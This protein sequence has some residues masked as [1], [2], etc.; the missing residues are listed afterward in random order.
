M[1]T[2]SDQNA[3]HS[4]LWTR[5]L[6]AAAQ[7]LT[8]VMRWWRSAIADALTSYPKPDDSPTGHA[9]GHD[10]DRILI[11]GAGPAV[12]W[13]VRTHDRGLPGA[14]ARALTA[15]T[16]RGSD[17]HVVA[18]ANMRVGQAPAALIGLR[19]SQYDAVVVM[20]GGNDALRL[21]PVKRWR[22]GLTVLL[23]E[24]GEASPGIL[25]AVAGIQPIR[26]IGVFD[27]LLGGVA[28]RRGVS[29]NHVTAQ[30]CLDTPY[31]VFVSTAAR[32]SP[33]TSGGRHM[34]PIDFTAWAEALADRIAPILT[35][36]HNLNG[37]RRR[38]TL[39]AGPPAPVAG[40][41]QAG[42]AAGLEG[43]ASDRLDC[44]VS[45]A[46]RAFRTDFA[47][48]SLLDGN[49]R[50]QLGNT[51]SGGH[52]EIAGF[53]SIY[54]IAGTGEDEMIVRDARADDRF[55]DHPMVV[56]E[57]HIRFIADFPIES[58]AGLRIGALCVLACTPR[59]RA[60]DIDVDFLRDLALMA[61]RELS[62]L[63]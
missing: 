13:G 59:R 5:A 39:P 52:A 16:G 20:L 3:Q 61:Q 8:P 23:D 57:P 37:D 17:V 9:S 10:C 28:Q 53:P 55:A 44:I 58:R 43:A 30:V 60:E 27:S 18:D 36:S 1:T 19:L 41:T 49:R 54:D 31:T 25:V 11:F 46:K 7:P 56:G 15:H 12:G 26:S 47:L 42:D 45:L 38:T 34:T 2:N 35:G 22:D 62:P 50:R 63:V 33:R 21:T 29:M 24:I 14:F 48:I 51:G 32:V 4:V 6:D 40:G